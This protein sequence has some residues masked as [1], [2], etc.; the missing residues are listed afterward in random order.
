MSSEHCLVC[1]IISLLKFQ[2]EN[3]KKYIPVL[4]GQNGLSFIIIGPHGFEES[5]AD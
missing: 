4:S 2:M 5:F 3:L 1:F